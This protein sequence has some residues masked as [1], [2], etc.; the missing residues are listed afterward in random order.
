M[1]TED[2]NSSMEVF[3]AAETFLNDGEE[4]CS[5]GRVMVVQGVL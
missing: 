2:T 4:S 1:E 3:Q 5:L